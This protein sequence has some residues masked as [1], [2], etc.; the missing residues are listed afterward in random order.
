ME[1]N[2]NKLSVDYFFTLRT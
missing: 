1:N 2:D